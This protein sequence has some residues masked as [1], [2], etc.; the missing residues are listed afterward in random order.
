MAERDILPDHFKPVH[1]DLVLT[2]LDF[3]QWSYKGAVT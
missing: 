2:D 3:D 1:Y